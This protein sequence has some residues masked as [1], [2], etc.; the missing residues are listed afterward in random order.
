MMTIKPK[1]IKKEGYSVALTVGFYEWRDSSYLLINI[2]NYLQTN[3]PEKLP[4]AISKDNFLKNAVML[5]QLKFKNELDR[6][7]EIGYVKTVG[8]LMVFTEK[9]LNSW[10]KVYEYQENS[11]FFWYFCEIYWSQWSKTQDLNLVF[12]FIL[13]Y[14]FIYV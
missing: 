2:I 12:Y 6:F 9:F 13:N 11:W 3:Y 1:E 4:G 14:Y 7:E 10:Q 8:N 5:N